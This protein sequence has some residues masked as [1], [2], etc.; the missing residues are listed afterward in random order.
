V[1]SGWW[2]PLTAHAWTLAGLAAAAALACLLLVPPRA[3]EGRRDIGL[4][5]LRG[6]AA[7]LSQ[8][9]PPSIFSFAQALGEEP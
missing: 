7:L 3:V 4:L 8:A 2:A 9:T 6:D 1:T 5:E